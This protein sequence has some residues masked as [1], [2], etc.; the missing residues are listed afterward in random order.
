MNPLLVITSTVYVNSQLTVLTDPGVRLSQYT[1][2][3]LFYIKSVQFA[4]IVICDN[5]GFDYSTVDVIQTTAKASNV[6]LEFL[7]FTG[8][9]EQ[10]QKQGKGYGE[11]EILHH[12]MQF[13]QLMRK[14]SAFMKVTGR[15]NVL[16]IGALIKA[17]NPE[18]NYFQ[19]I[20]LNPIRNRK[21]VDTRLYYCQKDDFIN[22][23]IRSYTKVNDFNG[24]YLERAYYEALNGRV[25]YRN[26]LI[27]PRFQG[28]SG[29]HGGSLTDVAALFYFKSYIN[30]LFIKLHL[31]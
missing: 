9:T 22:S 25:R 17:A 15:I 26:F 19:R 7:F 11:G 12:I 24:H 1:E 21:M 10:I 28:I 8:N 13:S 3:I 16:N 31:V 18:T 20:G 2:S 5:S 6:K 14:T 27:L 23:L 29:S 4:E 30:Y